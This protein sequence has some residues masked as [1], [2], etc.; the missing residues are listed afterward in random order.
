[1]V[2]SIND[3]LCRNDWRPIRVRR[4]WCEKLANVEVKPRG[5]HLTW[6]TPSTYQGTID[7]S[8]TVQHRGRYY[9]NI[10]VEVDTSESK[11]TAA[12]ASPCHTNKRWAL[13]VLDLERIDDL[14]DIQ[15]PSCRMIWPGPSD[16]TL[17]HPYS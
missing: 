9:G 10:L 4:E 2:H 6:T 13:V 7:A 17:F 1:M 3:G 8:K 11:T 14:F 15:R 12:W 16:S 5:R